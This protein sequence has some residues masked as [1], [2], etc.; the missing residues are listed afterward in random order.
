MS[1]SVLALAPAA[2]LTLGAVLLGALRGR[3]AGPV[4]AGLAALAVLAALVQFVVGVPDQGLLVLGDQF[5]VDPLSGLFD[6][7]LVVCMTGSLALSAGAQRSG[8]AALMM[9][10]TV[11]A[12]LAVH[13]VDLITLVL[14]LELAG[15][16]VVPM[17][18]AGDDHEDI[19]PD[20]R[21]LLLHGVSAAILLM[22]LA[23]LYGATSTLDLMRLGAKLG[24]LF[25][26]WA[27]G[28][29]QKAVE[30]LQLPQLPIGDQ[31]VAHLRDAAVK[32]TAPA[33][34]YIPGLL[35]T[36]TGLMTRLGVVFLHRGLPRVYSAAP[37][38]CVAFCDTVIRL[39]GVAAL[40]RVLPGALNTARLVYAP[41]GWTV[42]LGTLA[43]FTLVIGAL[44][45]LRPAG[46]DAPTLRRFMAWSSLYH[47]GWIVVGLIA[48]GD[49][50]AHAG[51]RPGG[52]QVGIS[53]EWGMMSGDRAMI[54]VLLLA[55]ASAVASLG[56]W[57]GL[58]FI[59]RA[60]GSLRGLG[61]SRPWL[62]AGMV[63]CLLSWIGAP[64]TGGFA[65][66]AALVLAG[67]VDSNAMVR[68]LVVAALIG[69]VAVAA[70]GLRLVVQMYVEPGEPGEPGEP[71]PARAWVPAMILAVMAALS[72]ALALGGSRSWRPFVRAGVGTSLS[73]GSDA[74]ALRI[75]RA[76]EPAAPHENS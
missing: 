14:G 68:A 17:I 11:G 59:E 36:L 22:G 70:R 24:A 75:Q 10:A 57:A 54:G 4:I 29:V 39:A 61:Q 56:V 37:L 3:S 63:I 73:H 52:L 31:G 5:V 76:L 8:R 53:Y 62:A 15:L 13:A 35:L 9:L 28:T 46:A 44:G 34:L 7:V 47:A 20:A 43:L 69:G 55:V 65:G 60:G 18:G 49:F 74:R 30:I 50:Y 2:V 51:L 48:A 32:G 38:S 16:A 25:T 1:A 45:A 23:L 41:Y 42:P 27:S 12:M 58:V 26:G 66:R 40:V 71:E 33:A 19:R 64:F 72:L 21:W 6:L 67:L